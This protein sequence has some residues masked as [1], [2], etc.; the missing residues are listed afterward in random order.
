MA[1]SIEVETAFR[2]RFPLNLTVTGMKKKLKWE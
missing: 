1:A 2:D